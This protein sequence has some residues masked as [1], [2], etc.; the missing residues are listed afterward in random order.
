MYVHAQCTLFPPVYSSLFTIAHIHHSTFNKLL[1]AQKVYRGMKNGTRPF[2]QKKMHHSCAQHFND[3]IMA[4]GVFVVEEREQPRDGIFS[5]LAQCRNHFLLRNSVTAF[6]FFF[7]F[8]T[9]LQ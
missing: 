9:K 4:D 6:F 7:F 2:Q 3:K 5:Y 1:L 8:L